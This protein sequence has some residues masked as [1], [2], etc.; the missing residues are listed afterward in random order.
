MAAALHNFF[1]AVFKLIALAPL[2]RTELLGTP[3]Q[4]DFLLDVSSCTRLAV[5]FTNVSFHLVKLSLYS[6]H[7]VAFPAVDAVFFLAVDVEVTAIDVGEFS[8]DMLVGIDAEA[9][10]YVIRN[11]GC[12]F[13]NAAKKEQFLAF[14]L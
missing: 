10:Q 5:G 14:F 8:L 9:F 2:E 11:D 12:L 3:F 6:I 7:H 13:F 1:F 4:S